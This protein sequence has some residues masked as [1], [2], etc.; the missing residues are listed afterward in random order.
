[1]ASIEMAKKIADD[2]GV[3]LDFLVGEGKNASFDKKTVQ[4]M[5]E[6]EN[7]DEEA[8]ERLFSVIDSV[9]SDYRTQKAYST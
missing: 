7:M 2:F 4:R 8:K 5:Q 6:I 3:S 1:M 9:I